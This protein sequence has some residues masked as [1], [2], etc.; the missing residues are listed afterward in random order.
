MGGEE[1]KVRHC[2]V[3][4]CSEHRLIGCGRHW[5]KHKMGPDGRCEQRHFSS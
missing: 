3:C 2:P 5:A 4:G 1:E